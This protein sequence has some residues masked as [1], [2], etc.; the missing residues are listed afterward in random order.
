MEKLLQVRPVLDTR[1]GHYGPVESAET[2][3]TYL[4]GTATDD[5]VDLCPALQHTTRRFLSIIDTTN[6]ATLGETRMDELP[7]RPASCL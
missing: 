5:M 7:L 3:A 1:N 2:Y 6:S 4:T